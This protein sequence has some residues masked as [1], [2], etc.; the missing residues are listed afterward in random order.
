MYQ[1]HLVRSRMIA[2]RHICRLG[3]SYARQTFDSLFSHADFRRTST[4]ATVSH[5]KTLRSL[6]INGTT[7]NHGEQVV[8]DYQGA[9][10]VY[11]V[12]THRETSS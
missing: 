2:A 8:P 5:M 9:R 7:Q 12:G 1:C 6:T 3:F 10:L 4:S 11:V